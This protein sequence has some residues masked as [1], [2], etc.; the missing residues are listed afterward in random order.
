MNLKK[1][2][3]TKFCTAENLE[4]ELS[5]AKLLRATPLSENSDLY[6]VCLNKKSQQD[7]IPVQARVSFIL[8]F[9]RIINF[10]F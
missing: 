5:K 8:F 7:I 10:I 1:R 4:K 2:T 6:E 3:L 9:D